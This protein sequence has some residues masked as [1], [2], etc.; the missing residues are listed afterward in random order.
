MILYL[1]LA[2]QVGCR[3]ILLAQ[4]GLLRNRR[5]A[6][7]W[8][9]VWQGEL[10]GEVAV[11]P[12]KMADA[13][14]NKTVGNANLHALT[15]SLDDRRP[16]RPEHPRSQSARKVP[17][18]ARFRSWTAGHFEC[19]A[20]FPRNRRLGGRSSSWFGPASGCAQTC[21]QIQ[22]FLLAGPVVDVGHAV[23]QPVR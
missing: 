22:A 3:S 8:R 7:P 10:R 5:N 6:R 18:K 14:Q 12:Y 23:V 13:V 16:V 15:R 21:K 9:W 4:L 2:S 19:P 1:R 17:R 11:Q 20:C